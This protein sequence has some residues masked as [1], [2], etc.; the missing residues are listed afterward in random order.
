[1]SRSTT[2]EDE[3]ETEDE[4]NLKIVNRS[5]SLRTNLGGSLLTSENEKTVVLS[6]EGFSMKKTDIIVS[7]S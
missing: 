3:V 5:Q 1:M 4:K 7:S 2:D 6:F